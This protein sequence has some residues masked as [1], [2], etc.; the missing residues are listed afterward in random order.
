MV[1]VIANKL[2][3]IHP[4]ADLFATVV[5]ASS[6]NLASITALLA[7]RIRSVGAIIEIF[8]VLS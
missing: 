8:A 1:S 5:G 7:D 2:N 4:T 6:V 3:P